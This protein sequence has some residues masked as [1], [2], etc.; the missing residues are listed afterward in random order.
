MLP[1]YFE[2]LDK[3]KKYIIKEDEKVNDY[4]NVFFKRV[5][6]S[7]SVIIALIILTMISLLYKIF[8][9]KNKYII[10]NNNKIIYKILIILFNK[11]FIINYYI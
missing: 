5:L 8:L 2:Y 11:F 9:I 4:D 6:I 7:I 3:P 10:I 1:Y